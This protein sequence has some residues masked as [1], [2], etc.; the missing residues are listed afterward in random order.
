MEVNFLYGYMS[1]VNFKQIYFDD[2]PH[3]L[4]EVACG[5]VKNRVIKPN[6]INNIY[7]TIIENLDSSEQIDS[8]KKLVK[9]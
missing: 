9:R 6:V 7:P 3:C 8:S 2:H 4:N 5:L 1:S